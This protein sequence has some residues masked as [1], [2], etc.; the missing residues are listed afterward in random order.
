MLFFIQAAAVFSQN[1]E[2]NCQW[3]LVSIENIYPDGKKVHPYGENPVGLLIFDEKGNY[4]IQILRE[5]RP[6]IAS[7][8][9]NNCTPEEYA[10]IVQGFNSH[11]GTYQLDK[12][13]QQI[14]FSIEHASFPNWEKTVQ[15]RSFTLKD[16][17]LKYVV[18][19]TTQGGQS[20]IAE[21]V[22]EKMYAK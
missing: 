8:D 12:E 16:G 7:G 2:L 3:S 9:K 4:A 20:V 22:W 21:V 19:H 5:S 10:S 6:I 1:N 15:K 13:H 17:V 14:S 18:T 11:F